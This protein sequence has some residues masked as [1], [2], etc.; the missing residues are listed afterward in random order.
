MFI[1][2]LLLN[3]QLVSSVLAVLHDVVC[4][5]FDP[6]FVQDLFKPKPLYERTAARRIFDRLAHAS[7]MKLNESSMDKV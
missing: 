7:I 6:L 5:M 3:L 4:A 2:V 1:H